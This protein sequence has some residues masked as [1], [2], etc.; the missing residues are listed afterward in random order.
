MTKYS[1]QKKFKKAENLKSI[2][3]EEIKENREW[4]RRLVDISE[5]DGNKEFEELVDSIVDMGIYE[6]DE[7]YKEGFIVLKDGSTYDFMSYRQIPPYESKF[8]EKLPEYKKYLLVSPRK[9]NTA[10]CMDNVWDMWVNG[11]KTFILE[12]LSPSKKFIGVVNTKNNSKVTNFYTIMHR[13]FGKD[14]ARKVAIKQ[15]PFVKH[16]TAI[17]ASM[18]DKDID[19]PNQVR[20]YDNDFPDEFHNFNPID[21]IEIYEDARSVLLTTLA[22]SKKE[23]LTLEDIRK[24]QKPNLT[25]KDFGVDLTKQHE[26]SPIVKHEA[27]SSNSKL[28]KFTSTL[29]A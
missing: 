7:T 5:F 29:E 3:E 20:F 13:W 26:F 18:V 19:S 8:S 24:A 12:K 28:D 27:T 10:Q 15:Q 22:V 23:A 6:A 4:F 14:W 1:N 16:R 21:L 17:K 25:L 9:I 2:S 11:G